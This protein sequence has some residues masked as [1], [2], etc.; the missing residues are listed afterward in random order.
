[1]SLDNTYFLAQ[2]HNSEYYWAKKYVL[3]EYVTNMSE[4]YKSEYWPKKYSRL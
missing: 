1:M 2:F 3:F 4:I